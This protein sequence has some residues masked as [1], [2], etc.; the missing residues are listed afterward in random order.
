MKKSLL[1]IALSVFVYGAGL[2]TA[3]PEREG[4]SPERLNRINLIM[5]D[6]AAGRLAG[7]SGLIARNGKVVFR[8]NWGEISRTPSCV[9]TR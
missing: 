7:A 6:I 2:P 1:A 8:E 4:F 3:S 9:C 5:Q